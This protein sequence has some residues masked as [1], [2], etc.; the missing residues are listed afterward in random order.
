M[1]AVYPRYTSFALFVALLSARAVGAPL[2]DLAEA[3]RWAE[4]QAEIAAGAD[5]DEAQADAST[6]L[7]WAAHHRNHDAVAWLIEAGA[8]VTASNDYGVTPLATAATVGDTALVALLLEAGASA[9]TVMPE[10]D[11][12][13]MLA[14]RSGN[15]RTVEL[16]LDAGAAI[17]ARDEW[18]GETALMWAAGEN[19]APIVDLLL[20][21]GAD[22]A[23]VSTEFT[24]NDVKQTGVA[25]V[26]PRGGLSALLHAARQDALE[27]AAVLLQHGADPNSKDPRGLS[28]IRIAITNNNLDLA[29]LLLEHGADPNEGALVEVVKLR[30]HPWVRAAKQRTD[31]TTQLELM[32]LLLARGADIHKVPTAGMVKQHWVDGEHPNEPPLYLAAQSADLELMRLLAARGA[33]AEQSRSTKGASILMAATG[34]TPYTGAGASP[35]ARPFAQGIAAGEVALEL[36]ADIH[37]ARSDGMTALHLAAAQGWNEVATFLLER[38]AKLDGRDKSGRLPIDVAKG[39]AAIPQPGDPPMMLPPT[40]VVHE[41]TVELLRAAMTEAGVAETSYQRPPAADKP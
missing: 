39:V 16:L 32:D 38:G 7:L 13:L 33:I 37:T 15:I 14:A 31:Q 5:V 10:G 8:D 26:L 23:L 1:S 27:A 11:T 4:L 41:S 25:S 28:A 40:P 19:H 21:R 29:K 12:A 30:T 35:I 36:G 22:V 17:D 20:E 9:N 18:H 24:W 2:P 3:Q 34:L 6:A